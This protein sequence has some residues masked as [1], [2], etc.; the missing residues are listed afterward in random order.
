L[1]E[2][3]YQYLVKRGLHVEQLDGDKV[4][5]IFPNTGFLKEDR[6]EHIKRVPDLFAETIYY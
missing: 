3:T 4:R 1:A 6:N 2:K 5:S